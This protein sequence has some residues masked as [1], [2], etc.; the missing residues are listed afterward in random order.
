MSSHAEQVAYPAK[1]EDDCIPANK[2]LKITREGSVFP[3]AEGRSVE[4]AVENFAQGDLV[5]KIRGRRAQGDLR[6][7]FSWRPDLARGPVRHA[8]TQ[9]FPTRGQERVA[10]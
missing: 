8:A 10:A 7:A 4:Y 6:R 9:G 1:A 2:W 5:S 3:W